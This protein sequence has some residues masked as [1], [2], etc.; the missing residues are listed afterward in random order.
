MSEVQTMTALAVSSALGVGMM[1]ALLGNLKLAL[2][3]RPD[4]TDRRV[5]LLLTLL[6]AL[7][8]PFLLL[9][10]VLVDSWGPR[11]MLVTGSVILALALLALSAGLE[12]RQTLTSVLFATLGASALW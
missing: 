5:R 11:P 12:Y 4:Q 7:L 3:R 6:N 1:L 10:G 9:C 8:I 2:A